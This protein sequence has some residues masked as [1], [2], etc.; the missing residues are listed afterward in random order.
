MTALID[1]RVQVPTLISHCLS[2]TNYKEPL[3]QSTTLQTQLSSWFSTHL[4]N[5][6]FAWA[7]TTNPPSSL[8]DFRL[9]NAFDIA[10]SFPDLRT[11][12]L[13]L[14]YWTTRLRIAKA[15]TDMLRRHQ[16]THLTETAESEVLL[17]ATKICQCIPYCCQPTAGPLPRICSLLSLVV[18]FEAFETL[19]HVEQTAWCRAAFAKLRRYGIVQPGLFP[20]ETFP[21]ERYGE[22]GSREESFEES[23]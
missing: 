13:H 15:V 5:T 8:L 3:R 12:C 2:T 23:F 4:Q 6:G 21:L 18:A 1:I 9:N 14:K 17:S 11:G 22:S 20:L 7:T 16:S 10:F 19:G